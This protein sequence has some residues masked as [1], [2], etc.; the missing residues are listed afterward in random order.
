MKNKNKLVVQKTTLEDILPLRHQFLQALNCQIRYDACH[1]RHWADEYLLVLNG[2]KVG[3]GSVKGKENLADRDAIFEFYVLPTYQK[4]QDL[5]FIELLKTSVAKFIECQSNDTNLTALLY[6]YAHQIYSDTILFE[7]NI[8]TNLQQPNII[9]RRRQDGDNVFGK[10]T[11]DEGAYVL[12]KDGII[13]ADGGFLLHYNK[14]FADLYMETSKAHRGQGYASF[15]LQ[16]LKKVCYQAGRVP[17]AR[18]RITNKGSKAA[19]L[20]AGMR[21]CGYML[22]GEI[23]ALSS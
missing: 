15:I 4:Y 5:L 14:P 11:A 22:I 7:D 2:K 1:V 23:K 10:S 9:F 20:K 12:E 18:C 21:V 13:V 8:T 17:A 16:A 3:Y 6:E 19:L